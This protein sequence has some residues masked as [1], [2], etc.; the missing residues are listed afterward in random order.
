MKWG[1]SIVNGLHPHKCTRRYDD[2]THRIFVVVHVVCSC[3]SLM[4]VMTKR[5]PNSTDGVKGTA[6][7][8]QRLSACVNGSRQNNSC[9]VCSEVIAGVKRDVLRNAST[10]AFSR[11]RW[12]QP[13]TCPNREGTHPSP[14]LSPVESVTKRWIQCSAMECGGR[15]LGGSE[16]G[17]NTGWY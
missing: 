12:R 6:S 16:G 9:F 5:F 14:A 4:I 13:S 7:S 17:E 8:I 2:S 1:S 3:C 10:D 15:I 11:L